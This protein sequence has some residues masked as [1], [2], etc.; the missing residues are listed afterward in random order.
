LVGIQDIDSITQGRENIAQLFLQRKDMPGDN[1]NSQ[2]IDRNI[3]DDETLEW[4]EQAL[5]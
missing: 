5:R 1:Q 3:P 2:V 4:C